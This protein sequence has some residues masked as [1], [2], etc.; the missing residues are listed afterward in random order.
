MQR[1]ISPEILVIDD[2]FVDQEA[3]RR[4]LLKAFTGSP[5]NVQACNSGS[6]ALA[7]IRSRNFGCVFLDYLLPDMTGVDL[8]RAIYDPKTDLANMPVVMLTGKGSEAVMLE[9][10]RW[11]A[12][13]YIVKDN[14]SPGSLK[15]AITKAKELFELK[16]SRY[17]AEEK[18]QHAQKMEAVGQLTSGVAHD[19]NNLLTVVLGNVY[20]IQELM[21]SAGDKVDPA[22]I[23]EELHAIETVAPTA[24]R[25][26]SGSWSSAASSRWTT[27][28]RT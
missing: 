27:R 14:I 9:A 8:L 20:L 18:L 22:S 7:L 24:R 5:V 1:V 13:D 6:E 2:D 21:E 25:W 16:R 3:I 10:L 23:A 4:H 12:Q 15:V 17:Q 26:S 11:G 19:F 28:S